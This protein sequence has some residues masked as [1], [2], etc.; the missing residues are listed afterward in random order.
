M[1]ESRLS[2]LLLVATVAAALVL[3]AGPAHH[4][5]AQV[6]PSPTAL[7]ALADPAVTTSGS[8]GVSIDLP[9]TTTSTLLPRVGGPTPERPKRDK[10]KAEPT[11]T[12]STTLAETTTTAATENSPT[13]TT[14]PPATTTTTTTPPPPPSGSF[15]GAFESQFATL[16]NDA[17]S[18][19]GKSS[20]SRNGTLDSEARK[21][22]K[23]M[24]QD[25]NLTHSDIGRFLPPW[26]SVGENI[27]YGGSVSSVFGNLYSSD[28]HRSNM[29]GNYTHM[30]IGVWV[31]AGGTIWTCHVF[32]S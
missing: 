8:Y 16:I 31:D 6:N 3:V 15:N 10:K 23:K 30:G 28:G 26:G 12:T 4:G 14:S 27:A 17:R 5:S 7:A 25:G 22:A 29:L 24:A 19:A 13:S 1:N 32:A 20:L 9:G 21:W 2:A 18:D 11:T